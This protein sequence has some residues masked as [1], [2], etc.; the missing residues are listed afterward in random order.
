VSPRVENPRPPLTCRRASTARARA[1]RPAAPARPTPAG[2][3]LPPPHASTRGVPDRDSPPIRDR[4]L[5]LLIVFT[6]AMLV[7][8]GL[9]AITAVVGRWWILVP[10]MAVDLAATAAVLG[11]VARLM[12]DGDG[13]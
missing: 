6:T 11:S 5:T 1:A 13:R 12:N 9:A 2:H 7:I 8:V 3:D 10:V 4:G